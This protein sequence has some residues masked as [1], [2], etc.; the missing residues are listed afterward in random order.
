LT[1]RPDLQGRGLGRQLG[2]AVIDWAAAAG[3]MSVVVDWRMANLP[4][5]RAWPKLGFTPTFVRMHRL[6]GY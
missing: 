2:A 1:V 6:V 3:R 4:A 5:D